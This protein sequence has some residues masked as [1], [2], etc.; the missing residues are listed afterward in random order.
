MPTVHPIQKKQRRSL[1][2]SPSSSSSASPSVIFPPIR[3]NIEEVE[4]SLQDECYR[5]YAKQQRQQQQW[6]QQQSQRTSPP[7]DSLFKIGAKTG[8]LPF[9]SA[10]QR[11]SSPPPST[12][13]ANPSSSLALKRFQRSPLYDTDTTS[14]RSIQHDA[15]EIVLD[16]PSFYSSYQQFIQWTPSAKAVESQS[17][18]NYVEDILE[19]VLG[20]TDY[21]SRNRII[22]PPSV[23]P[24]NTGILDTTSTTASDSATTSTT[25]NT[26]TDTDSVIIDSTS[27]TAASTA[28]DTTSPTMAPTTPTADITTTIDV[29][30][31]AVDTT[32][33]TMAST[34]LTTDTTTT[35]DVASTAMDTT[36]PTMVPTSPT[37]DTTTTMDIAS[38]TLGNTF[39]VSTAAAT[40]TTTTTT[41]IDTSATSATSVTDTMA[42]APEAP[43]SSAQQL[44]NATSTST[45]TTS[46]SHSNNI[47]PVFATDFQLRAV[48]NE[49]QRLNGN[50]SSERNL[51]NRIGKVIDIF[52]HPLHAMIPGY[53]I[54]TEGQ[55]ADIWRGSGKTLFLQQLIARLEDQEQDF[56]IAIVCYDLNME[57]FLLDLFTKLK[58]PATRLNTVIKGCWQKEHGIVLCI[59]KKLTE[60]QSVHLQQSSFTNK[61]H[62]VISCDVRIQ[63]ND[64]VVTLFE[65]ARENAHHSPPP[66][67][68]LSTVGSVEERLTDYS[69]STNPTAWR[70]PDQESC[71]TIF[72]SGAD[73]PVEHPQSLTAMVVDSVVRWIS[74]DATL[75]FSLGLDQQEDE[76]YSEP[77]ASPPPRSE[78]PQPQALPSPQQENQAQL[79]PPHLDITEETTDTNAMMDIDHDQGL[80]IDTEQPSQQPPPNA[81][82]D[83]F[84]KLF[85]HVSLDQ[86]AT[87]LKSY[88]SSHH[89]SA[90]ELFTT[91][92]DDDSFYSAEMESSPVD[93][94]AATSVHEVMD[95]INCHQDEEKDVQL[96]NALKSLKLDFDKKCL[97]L[98]AAMMARYQTEVADLQQ[99]FVKQAELVLAK[100]S[101]S[102]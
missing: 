17:M 85:S 74:A 12:T 77:Q 53:N 66:V 14:T 79:S 23:T 98:Y 61:V 70:I 16:I 72:D 22:A 35:I 6:Q 101:P 40:T 67:I 7:L 43:I 64:P 47:V 11:P 57:G 100:N 71:A 93:D 24:S 29:A 65:N 82:R 38:T 58:Y 89:R 27:N 5:E 102:S 34:S 21:S 46:S 25:F 41:T 15:P 33:P 4:K 92:S 44:T 96:A 48:E 56:D 97:D 54:H 19:E 52:N 9:F 49:I 81:R 78:S 20:E 80:A 2:S 94:P 69:Q 10:I 55:G 84:I 90:K 91:T 8:T 26:T 88:E 36:S 50:F 87:N 63:P 51:K 31:T 86:M 1:F 68:L 13:Q 28:M 76:D 30:C 60:Q 95:K 3:L 73:K 39:S 37:T 32:S 83:D 59:R 45:T 42:T 62:L 75:P 99:D 18:R